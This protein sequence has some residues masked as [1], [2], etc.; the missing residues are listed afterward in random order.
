M[1]NEPKT[2]EY[3]QS[4]ILKKIISAIEK[5]IKKD[6]NKKGYIYYEYF[7]KAMEH[8]SFPQSK[9]EKSYDSKL[10]YFSSPSNQDKNSVKENALWALHRV[11]SRSQF[12]KGIMLLTPTFSAIVSESAIDYG[13]ALMTKENEILADLKNNFENTPIIEVINFRVAQTDN[14][15]ILTEQE[16]L[17][18]STNM[19]NPDT[20]TFWKHGKL[21]DNES[22]T[23][24]DEQYEMSIQGIE[25]LE[26]SLYGDGI[27][28]RK[29]IRYEVEKRMKPKPK[30]R[31]L[32]KFDHS[33]YPDALFKIGKK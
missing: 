29:N 32:K 26:M 22:V 7:D 18:V 5:K 4:A 3:K 19:E 23:I 8:T 20:A 21:S 14:Y 17:Y 6:P 11:L 25:A 33:K 1:L 13:Y 2:N 12:K 16:Y 24:L 9:F 30:K 31:P 27:F 15:I 10:N 28:I